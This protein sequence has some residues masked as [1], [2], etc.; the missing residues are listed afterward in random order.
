M[1]LQNK[2]KCDSLS[3]LH[4]WLLRKFI[5]GIDVKALKAQ[6]ALEKSKATKK[7]V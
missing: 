1:K 7:A 2:V 3:E 6:W 5:A 4:A